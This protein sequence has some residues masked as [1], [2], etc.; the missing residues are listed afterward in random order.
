MTITA[1][2]MTE[3]DRADNPTIHQMI[4]VRSVGQQDNSIILPQAFAIA[5]P[6]TAEADNVIS[7]AAPQATMIARHASGRPWLMV[8]MPQAYVTASTAPGTRIVAVGTCSASVEDLNRIARRGA[9]LSE[10]AAEVMRFDGSFTV[11]ALRDATILACGPAMQTHRVFHARIFG[12]TIVSDRADT[13][14]A[15]GRLPLDTAAVARSLLG[16]QPNFDDAQQPMWKGIT[17][18]YG[19]H[20][21]TVDASASTSTHAWWRRPSPRLSRSEGAALLRE[22]LQ[23]AVAARSQQHRELACDLSGGLD[24]T[25]VCYYASTAPQGVTALTFYSDDPG[26]REDL[27]W[28]EI[29]AQAMPRVR[30]EALWLGDAPSFYEGIGEMDIPVDEP[31]QVPLTAPRILYALDRDRDQ[32]IT[33][34]LHGAGGDHLFRGVPAWDHSIARRHPILGWN[35]ARAEA[36]AMKQSSLT[37]L[38]RLIDRRSYSRW[39]KDM[40][41]ESVR[42]SAETFSLRASDWYTPPRIP[43]WIAQEAREE[44]IVSMVASAEHAKPLSLERGEHFDLASIIDASRVTR[45]MSQVGLHKGI[46][47]ESPLMDDHVV[48]A[49]L[50]VAYIDRD[51]PIEWKPLMKAAMRGILPDEYLLRTTKVGGSP[52]AVRGYAQNF[53]TVK[54]LL[55]ESSLMD[56]GIIDRHALEESIRPSETSMPPTLISQLINTA[57]FLRNAPSVTTAS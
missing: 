47:Y 37:A 36:A 18:V 10:T 55:D 7:I 38:R 8:R 27:R 3:S 54:D 43:A 48:E 34:H 42:P 25:P 53:S 13:L 1:P 39:L 30:H 19:G 56:L 21:L 5:V 14:A 12:T 52:Q 57:L 24:S 35:R 20:C 11:Y 2:E 23:A 15:L 51:S 44:L 41:Y 31:T 28:A 6:D 40:A 16:S 22:R 46:G 45:G 26:G 33:M 32:G 29:A 50:S 17:P 49:V 9:S 4:T